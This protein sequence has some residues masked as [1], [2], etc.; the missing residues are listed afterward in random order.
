MKKT[1]SL[2]TVILSLQS[3]VG[4]AANPS[5]L[6]AKEVSPGSKKSVASKAAE[7]L[8]HSAGHHHAVTSEQHSVEPT[9]TVAE[10][11]PASEYRSIAAM[12]SGIQK[13]TYAN[14]NKGNVLTGA[15]FSLTQAWYRTSDTFNVYA[16]IPMQY[17]LMDRLALGGTAAI[18][19]SRLSSS[20]SY[21]DAAVGPSATL[22]FWDSENVATYVD[23]A[24]LW[25]F[26]DNSDDQISLGFGLGLDYF[27]TPAV[28]FGPKVTY[29]HYFGM[30]NASDINSLNLAA[31]F[32]ISL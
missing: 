21:T 19:H 12:F 18:S 14:I 22:Y 3:V 5:A 17:F 9:A 1:K 8:K 32:R 20:R 13:S 30:G 10:S 28:A 2:V 15:E 24:V 26:L 23:T 16:A 29:T 6:V 7:D 11:A 25:R 27:V 31:A 4:F